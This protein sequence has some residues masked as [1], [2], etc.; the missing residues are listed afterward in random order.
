MTTCAHDFQPVA[1]CGGVL[2]VCTV[3]GT[4]RRSNLVIPTNPTTRH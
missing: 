4:A 3:C 2:L 1:I